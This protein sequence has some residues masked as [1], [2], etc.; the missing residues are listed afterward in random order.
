MKPFNQGILTSVSLNP[1]EQHFPPEMHLWLGWA[2]QGLQLPTGT[3]SPKSNPGD[4]E[5]KVYFF[6]A[7]LP[8]DNIVP[9]LLAGHDTLMD[10]TG[11]LCST[12]I[13]ERLRAAQGAQSTASVLGGDVYTGCFTASSPLFFP[14]MA[15]HEGAASARR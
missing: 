6:L 5:Q 3:R 7:R 4:R 10:S 9:T 11:W 12:E 14:R 15:A 13:P 1:G 8:S 2:T